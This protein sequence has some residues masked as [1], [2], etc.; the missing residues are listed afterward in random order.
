MLVSLFEIS[1]PQAKRIEDNKPRQPRKVRD[2]KR[3]AVSRR[4]GFAHLK[5]AEEKI[6]RIFSGKICQ[7]HGES[8]SRE[9]LQDVVEHRHSSKG[10]ADPLPNS[11]AVDPV[12]KT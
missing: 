5:K 4:C 11:F 6:A 9:P 2:T 1:P 7:Q 3:E 8:M 10:N 12:G